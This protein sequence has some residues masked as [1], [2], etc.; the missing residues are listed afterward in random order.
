MAWLGGIF[1]HAPWVAEAAYSSRPFPSIERLHASMMHCVRNVSEER[2][3]ALLKG[4][5]ELAGKA[6]QAGMMTADSTFEQDSAGLNRLSQMELS[7]FQRL[8]KAYSEKFGFPFIICVRRHSKDSIFRQFERRL[9]ND[10]KTECETAIAEVGRITALR[11]DQRFAPD[12]SLKLHGRLAVHVIDL[13]RGL[14][15]HGMQVDLYAI[16]ASGIEYALRSERV[17]SSGV[18]VMLDKR[19]LPAGL[20]ELRFHCREYFNIQ[21]PSFLDIIPVRFSVA[22]SDGDYHIPLRVSQSSY[23]AYRGF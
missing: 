2:R 19:P 12:G 20:Y 22:E 9:S 10:F 6:A 17:D 5:P 13:A 16:E 21:Q 23:F 3:L 8:N 4:H 18:A 1:E 15:A 11:L 7:R 14:P